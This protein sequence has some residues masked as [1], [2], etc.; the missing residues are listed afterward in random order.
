MAKMKSKSAA[1]K[2]FKITGSGKVKYKK[3]NLRHILTKKS[4]KRK[5]NLRKPGILSDAD[6]K[7]V[8]KKLLPYS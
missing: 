4:P 2:R 7:V 8:R 1:A 6:T 3:M 5:R